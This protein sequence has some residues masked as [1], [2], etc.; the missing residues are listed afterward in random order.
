MS[1]EDKIEVEGQIIKSL[2]GL[3]FE[4]QLPEN[5]GGGIVRGHLSGNMRKNYIK[6]IEGDKVTI[7]LSPYDPG[8]GRITY[9][10]QAERNS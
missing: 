9:R 10:L 4:V 6:L 3:V 2:P 5:L 7:E 8:K 1:K